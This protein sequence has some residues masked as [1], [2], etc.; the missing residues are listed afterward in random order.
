MARE[1]A[2]RGHTLVYG[3]GRV[4]LMGRLADTVL[5]GGGRVIGVIPEALFAKEVAH[6]GLTDLRVVASMHER[7]QVMSDLADGVV[8][9]PGGLGTLEEFFEMLTWAQLGFHAKPCGLFNVCGYFDELL[10]FL[11]R[12]VAEGFIQPAHRTLILADSHPAALLDR[13]ADYTPPTVEKWLD[14]AST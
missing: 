5:E 4:G 2:A 3:G 6:H 1:L 11:D 9:I 8:A 10:R 14:R 13:M 7:K 12:A